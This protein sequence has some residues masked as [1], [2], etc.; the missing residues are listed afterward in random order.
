MTHPIIKELRAARLADFRTKAREKEMFS[1]LAELLTKYE[2][3]GH[4]LYRVAL[5]MKGGYILK[6]PLSEDGEFCNDGE[7]SWRHETFAKGRYVEYRGF[8]CVVQEP[9]EV[10]SPADIEARLGANLPDWTY[11]VDCC[12][13]GFAR[14]GSLKAYDF[15]HP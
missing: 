10:L 11:S 12:Q 2:Y 9:I 4:G 3:V 15:V 13:V 5:R 14:D 1:V 7:G 6:F 8:V